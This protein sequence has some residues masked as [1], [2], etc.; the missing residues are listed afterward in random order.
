MMTPAGNPHT[1][2]KAINPGTI[3]VIL[4]THTIKGR[5]QGS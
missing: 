4:A 2:L 3:D 5:R 1:M